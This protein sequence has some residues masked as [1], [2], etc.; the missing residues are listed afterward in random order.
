[1]CVCVCVC[2]S[3][4]ACVSQMYRYGTLVVVGLPLCVRCNCADWSFGTQHQA[5]KPTAAAAD[6]PTNESASGGGGG[7]ASKGEG[8][9]ASRANCCCVARLSVCVCSVGEHFAPPVCLLVG[10]SE[11]KRICVVCREFCF[12]C[13]KGK[14][15]LKRVSNSRPTISSNHFWTRLRLC[16]DGWNKTFLLSVSIVACCKPQLDTSFTEEHGG[17]QSNSILFKLPNHATQ[18]NVGSSRGATV[19]RRQDAASLM[20]IS[21]PSRFPMNIVTSTSPISVFMDRIANFDTAN[22][23]QQRWKMTH[24]AFQQPHIRT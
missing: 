11:R 7:A 16:R 1:M 2:L 10:R 18:T 12:R 22:Q 23:C 14:H 5:S 13:Q 19:E 21:A 6:E 9:W 20:T 15:P 8:E 24:Q 3:V 4:C 17:K